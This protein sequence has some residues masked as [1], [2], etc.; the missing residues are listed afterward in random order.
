MPLRGNG[1]NYVQ[2]TLIAQDFDRVKNGKVEYETL[3]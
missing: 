2:A 1:T 3:S